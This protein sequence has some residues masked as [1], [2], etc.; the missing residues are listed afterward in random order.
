MSRFI[1]HSEMTRNEILDCSYQAMAM[2]KL[3][4]LVTEDLSG[5]AP[6]A[7]IGGDVA[8]VLE[9]AAEMMA[10]VHDAIEAH[11]GAAS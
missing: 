9:L 2:V 3:A 4:R 1:N 11:E 5:T 8:I 7:A 6:S 10:V